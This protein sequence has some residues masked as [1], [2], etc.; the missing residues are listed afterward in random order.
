MYS[1]V[2]GLKKVNDARLELFSEVKKISWGF[3]TNTNSPYQ[4]IRRAVL[5]A[6]LW[7]QVTSEHMDIP[8]FKEWGWYKNSN[9]VLLPYWTDLNDSSKACSL[10]LQCECTTS[11]EKKCKCIRDGVRC[12]VVCKCEGGCKNN[13]EQWIMNLK[14][15]MSIKALNRFM[16]ST[17]TTYLE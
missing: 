7:S 9:G 15:D 17:F 3:T 13:S 5:Q 10:L 1:K 4:H 8:D 16:I 11:C 2:C 12:T 14:N 6:I